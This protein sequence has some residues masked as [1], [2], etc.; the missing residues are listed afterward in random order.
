MGGGRWSGYDF[1]SEA[2][3]IDVPPRVSEVVRYHLLPLIIGHLLLPWHPGVEPGA[4][5]MCADAG[6]S[7]E[8]RHLPLHLARETLLG[9]RRQH[10]QGGRGISA[11]A[12]L[13]VGQG[14]C[15]QGTIKVG[16]AP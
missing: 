8:Q 5:D 10:H 3:V 12:G 13:G 1:F 4:H 9:L 16:G 14:S 15:G 2:S 11:G 7:R 6:A